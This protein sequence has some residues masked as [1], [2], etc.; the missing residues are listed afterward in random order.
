[1]MFLRK[2]F[3]ISIDMTINGIFLMFPSTDHLHTYRNKKASDF[4]SFQSKGLPSVQ[5]GFPTHL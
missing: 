2:V 4:V 1:M 3:C 5:D